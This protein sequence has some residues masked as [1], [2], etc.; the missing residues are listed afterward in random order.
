[1]QLNLRHVHLIITPLLN[2]EIKSKD[3]TRVFTEN[4]SS[5]VLIKKKMIVL[6]SGPNRIGQGIEFDYCCVHGVLAAQSVDMKL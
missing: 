1:M 4:E 6:G 2:N 3:G 5:C